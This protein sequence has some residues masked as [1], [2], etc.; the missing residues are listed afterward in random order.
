MTASKFSIRKSRYH[1]K[2]EVTLIDSDESLH[3]RMQAGAGPQFDVFESSEHA[4]IVWIEPVEDGR[5]REALWS[6][7]VSG[8]RPERF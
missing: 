3:D 5:R 7:I 8:D 4:H 6:R 1:A 2:V